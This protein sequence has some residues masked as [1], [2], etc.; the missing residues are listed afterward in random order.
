[1]GK[2]TGGIGPYTYLWNTG[3]TTES[4]L[5]LPYRENGYQVAVIDANNCRDNKAIFI[6]EPDTIDVTFNV[7]QSKQPFCP[8]AED[9]VI[10]IDT[11]GATPGYVITWTKDGNAIN[12][13]TRLMEGNYRYSIIDAN[14][15]PF[16][17]TVI[18]K[19]LKELCL[20]IPN[21]FSP[22]GDERNQFW[23]IFAGNPEERNPVSL[24]Y[25]E[26][27][28]EVFNRWGELVFRSAPGYPEPWDGKFKG[29]TLPLDSY[30]YVIDPKNGKR[31]ISG[32]ITIVR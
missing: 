3:A 9:G 15:C 1:M 29:R 22:N 26:A 17:G 18:L 13:L 30:Y 5:N 4:L 16:S 7:E 19:S 25:P 6:S 2:T 32:I 28:I 27:V 8:D 23:V 31:Q 14:G 24:V 12:D 20:D 21:A 11:K 10:V